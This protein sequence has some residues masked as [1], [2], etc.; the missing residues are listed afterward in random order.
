MDRVTRFGVSLPGKLAAKFNTLT[1]EL[2]YKNRSK[3]IKD[4][5]TEFINQ[6]RLTLD[7]EKTV[8]GSISFL[9]NHEVRGATHKLTEIQHHHDRLIKSAMH[10]HITR[11][12]CIEVLI[13][14]GKMSET[15]SLFDEISAVRG[16]EN[17]K[18]SVLSASD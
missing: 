16:V 2:G 4:A 14:S 7:G 3:A 1:L 5:V 13:V 6:R 10:S 17:C 9:Y 15:K 8:I 18:L 11:E 12:H